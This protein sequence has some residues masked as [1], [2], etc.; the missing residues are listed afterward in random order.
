MQTPPTRPRRR[1]WPAFIAF[2][3]APPV[4]AGVVAVGLFLLI[5]F[6]LQVRRFL[7]QAGPLGET[8][9]KGDLLNM[10]EGLAIVGSVVEWTFGLGWRMLAIGKNWRRAIGYVL[11]G[12]V[13]GRRSARLAPSRWPPW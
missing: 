7:F 8:V 6:L 5:L 11:A 9:S 10:W 3:I 4:A 2:A 13:L 12:A 1:G